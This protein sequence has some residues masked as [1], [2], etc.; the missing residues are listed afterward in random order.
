[1]DKSTVNGAFSYGKAKTLLDSPLSPDGPSL[2]DTLKTSGIIN[3]TQEA[4]I[5]K[6]L[7]AG[8]DQEAAKVTGVKIQNFGQEPKMLGR[9]VAKIIGVKL[10][11]H[12]GMM[13]G[14]A[15][16]SLQIANMVS[17]AAEKLF[18]NMPADQAEKF[19]AQALAAKDTAALQAVLER[20]TSYNIARQKGT[21]AATKALVLSRAAIPRDQSKVERTGNSYMRPAGLLVPQQPSSGLLQ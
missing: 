21:S 10:A 17:N 1:M 15:G 9:Y 19:M 4:A 11:S 20:V 12:L 7:K 2:M 3:P 13:G 16:P 14:G 6:H 5:A 18:A 8:M